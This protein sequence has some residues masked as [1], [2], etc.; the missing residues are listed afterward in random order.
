M[1]TK[2]CSICKV[3]KKIEDFSKAGRGKY[4]PCCKVCY[5]ERYGER[6]KEASRRSYQNNKQQRDKVNKQWRVNN[7]EQIKQINKKSYTVN[8]DSILQNQ[9]QRRQDNP[10]YYANYAKNREQNDL[11]FKL[12]RRLRSR[13]YSLMKG[14]KSQTTLQLLGCSANE[15]RL[16]L[17]SKF[18]CWMNWDNYGAYKENYRTWHIDHIKPCASFDLTQQ[19]QQKQCFHYTNLQPLLAVDNLIKGDTYESFE[20]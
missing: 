6:E 17:E 9:K 18:E 1:E 8:R 4:R 12:T 7:P 10:E 19:D 5:K 13:I 15:F 16:Y 2:Y 11:N 20:N 3:D 14:S